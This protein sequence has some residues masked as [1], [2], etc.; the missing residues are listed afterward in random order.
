VQQTTPYRRRNSSTA[1]AGRG[2][3][4]LVELITVMGIIGILSAMAI[5]AYSNY[6]SKVVIAR[7]VAEIRMLETSIAAYRT[8]NGRQPDTL[9]DMGYGNLLDPWG[10]PYQYL[11][12]ADG[13]LHGKGQ[14]R[15]DRFLNPLNSDFDLYSMGA[16]GKSKLP[17]ST[18]E[19][20]DDILRANNGGFVGLASD[21]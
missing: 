2:G 9:S 4:T 21:F 7:T 5:P 18:K 19:S 16:D 15:K 1:S 3:F 8:S 12:I 11:N 10:H 20:Q 13:N 14:L 17:L 6:Y